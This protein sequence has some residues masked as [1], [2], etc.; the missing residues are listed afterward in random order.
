MTKNAIAVHPGVSPASV[1]VWRARFADEGL[2]E[3]G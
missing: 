1:V 2:S 3:V